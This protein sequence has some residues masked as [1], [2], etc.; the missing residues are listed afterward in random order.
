MSIWPDDDPTGA[1]AADALLAAPGNDVACDCGCHAAGPEAEHA[2][3]CALMACPD[4]GAASPALCACRPGG[5]RPDLDDPD[6]EMIGRV[7]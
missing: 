6:L 4:C 1:H 2:S 5:P 3:W 7:F